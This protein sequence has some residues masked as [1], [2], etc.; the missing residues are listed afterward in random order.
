MMQTKTIHRVR[1]MIAF[2]PVALVIAGC[3]P[4]ADPGDS[5]PETEAASETTSSSLDPQLDPQLAPSETLEEALL[6]PDTL[7]RIESVASLLRARTPDRLEETKIT[8]ERAVLDRGDL[9]YVLFID[10]WARFA[11]IEAYRYTLQHLRT[12]YPRT[13][14]AAAR[15]WARNDP[16]GA[17]ASGF[18]LDPK[19]PT[20]NY[21]ADML[22][23]LVVGWFESG[24]P[25]LQ[26]F[27]SG[28]SSLNDVTRG[29]RTYARL[30]VLREG[31]EET[32]EW[33]R[34]P[35]GFPAEHHRLLLAGALTV[36]AHQDPKLAA[37][38]LPVAEAD[39]IDIASFAMRIAGAWAHHDPEAAI[40][41]V[42]T[43]PADRNRERAFQRVG[44]Q[45]NEAA[46]E[47][48]AGW[49]ESRAG[50]ARLDSM[51]MI[52]IRSEVRRAGYQPNWNHVM[53]RLDEV[54]NEGTRS[55][56][57]VWALQRWL[58]VEPVAAEAWIEVHRDELTDQDIAVAH[59]IS[60]GDQLK[61][62]KALAGADS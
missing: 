3:G 11:P 34:E 9:E 42:D 59:E 21:R 37:S 18:F 7:L 19:A 1:Q 58:F 60:P 50:L 12:E 47:A 13:V 17:V 57:R 56:L 28:L 10:W 40:E 22:D 36:I 45:W 20:K 6:I 8:F 33:T 32:L 52:S 35:S 5:G 29:M 53:G 14:L 24:K 46:P 55:S 41:W 44:M 2:A 61:V 26:E 15:A 25:G 30:H 27:L 38:W 39:G 48:F 31:T 23:A 43:L 16:E 54:V 62:E 4:A 51:R 49:L